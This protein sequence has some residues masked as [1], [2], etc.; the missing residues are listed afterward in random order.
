MTVYPNCKFNLGLAVV[1]RREDGYH[2][3]STVM[4]PVS[5]LCD[6]L[7]ID[8]SE[9]EMSFVQHGIDVGCPVESNLCVRAYRLM[10]Q[11]Y[12][13]GPVRMT[14]EK[15]VPFGAG[16]GGGSA[17]ATY[18][19]M[20]LAD[21]FGLGLAEEELIA[22]ASELGSDTA[23]FV[24]RTPQLCSGR[25]EV[26]SDIDLPVSG[27]RLVLVKPDEGVSTAEAYRGVTPGIPEVPL[28]E[29]VRRPIEEWRSLIFNDFE[30]SVFRSHP[31]IGE[32]KRRMYDCGALYASMSG[33]GASVFGL[34]P[35]DAVVPPFCGMFS[36]SEILNFR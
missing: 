28:D 23:F 12:G 2:D 5:G 8:R 22:L 27:L 7:T 14:L 6:V 33:S 13:I 35:A 32:C 11:R 19:L 16:I 25:G 1:R 18:T 29:A 30:D 15:H 20:A 4:V 26:M 10:Q 17:D 21:M 3:L 34:F 31:V 36:Y 9:G 24:R